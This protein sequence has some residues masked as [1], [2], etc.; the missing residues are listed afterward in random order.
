[1]KQERFETQGRMATLYLAEEAGRPLVVLNNFAGDGGSVVKALAQ[2]GAPELNLLCIG[3]LAWDHDMTPWH[4]PPLSENDTPCTGGAS[5][6]L[7]LLLNEILPHAIDLVE[8]EPA[9]TSIAGYSLAGLFALWAAYNC[10]SF[11]SVASVSGSLWFPGFEEY[12]KERAFARAPEK[13]YVSLGDKEA[14]TRN[15]LLKTVQTRTEALVAHYRQIGLNVQW[16][17]NPGNH[18]Q[19]AALRSAKGI[20]AIL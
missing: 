7:Q 16:E 4:C 17:L 10:D 15:E 14:R 6:Y 3:N 18:I 19:D 13:I 20:A 2:V 9:H 12:C 5:D 11:A 8:G 1:M